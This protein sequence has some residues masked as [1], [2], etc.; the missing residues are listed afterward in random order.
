MTALPARH[1]LTEH[2]RHEER[3]ST[4]SAFVAWLAAYA[5]ET[6]PA[7]QA[8]ARGALAAVAEVLGDAATSWLALDASGPPSDWRDEAAW[9]LDL[10]TLAL[11]SEAAR[12]L[13]ETLRAAIVEHLG[14]LATAAMLVF[15]PHRL[16]LNP[17]VAAESRAGTLPAVFPWTAIRSGVACGLLRQTGPARPDV[18]EAWFDDRL[19]AEDATALQAWVASP[20]P[21]QSAYREMLSELAAEAGVPHVD[22]AR[23]IA[24]A[25]DLSEL[26]WAERVQVLSMPHLGFGVTR[27]GIL[28]QD[29]TWW[30]LTGTNELAEQHLPAGAKRLVWPDP[31]LGD[32][33][34]T[35]H[36]WPADPLV[37]AEDARMSVAR[38]AG[39]L[40]HPRARTIALAVAQD[41]RAGSLFEGLQRAAQAFEAADLETALPERWA[42]CALAT[43]LALERLGHRLADPELDLALA[44]AEAAL[45]PVASGLMLIDDAHYRDLVAEHDVDEN[46]WWGLREKLDQLVPTAAVVVALEELRNAATPRSVVSLS[47]YR[48]ATQRRTPASE[49]TPA[50]EGLRAVAAANEPGTVNLLVALEGRGHSG[51]VL[52]VSVQTGKDAPFAQNPWFAPVARDAIRSAYAAAGAAC[53]EGVP[54]LALED[55]SILVHHPLDVA[56]I[57]GASL[58]LAFALAFA[59]RWLD[60]PITPGLAAS[61]RLAFRSGRWSVA[62]VDHMRAK[63]AAFEAYPVQGRRL[64]VAPEHTAEIE[65]FDLEAV[66]VETVDEALREA[67]L[68]LHASVLAGAWPD[69][70]SRLSALKELLETIADQDIERFSAWGDPWRFIADRVALLLHALPDGD[71]DLVPQARA[72][73]ALAYVHAGDLDAAGA[74]L[75]G[76]PDTAREPADDPATHVVSLIVALDRAI[77]GEAPEDAS[78]LALALDRAVPG[79]A[80]RDHRLLAGQA[81]GTRGRA[82]LHARDFQ[83]ARGWLEQ[84]AQHHAVNLPHEH[85]RSLVYVAAALRNLGRLDEAHAQL[86]AAEE[87]LR[88]HT[89]PFSLAYASQCG[90]YLRY[91]RARLAIAQGDPQAALEDALQA[92]ATVE[93]Q[94]FWPALG[95]LRVLAWAHRLLDD[96][97]DADRYVER[98]R[99]LDVPS[100]HIA[101]RDRLIEE[102]E[103]PPISGGEV[104]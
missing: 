100:G 93:R 18:L 78:R 48:V 37:A 87:A 103:G 39:G 28:A 99:E 43:Q 73:G 36:P 7:A 51:R 71:D 86:V 21:W 2:L 66:P 35:L 63:A 81:W 20:G 83:G 56:V 85:G 49:P 60:R 77:D 42:A 47:A 50:Y 88:H 90:A 5:L 6:D 19:H 76:L 12:S 3:P 11:A 32:L 40:P 101:L 13:S 97:D 17:L 33:T 52:R 45:T 26:A 9:L 16:W 82:L 91:E 46:A 24:A 29:G 92:Y 68:D 10:E 104:Y 22:P 72:F 65:T 61:G 74:L 41:L 79:L 34:T 64:M 14:R 58:G 15:E 44:E 38:L 102:A 27:E 55:H 1:A 84:A 31:I 4:P 89:R 23:S 69:R 53:P 96:P 67:G 94:G 57:D 59:S 25:A 30:R 80:P 8:Q 62:P 75:A 95:I 54:P 70:R 98:M